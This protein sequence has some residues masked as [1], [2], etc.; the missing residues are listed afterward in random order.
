MLDKTWRETNFKKNTTSEEDI[1]HFLCTDIRTNT[2]LI[3]L[4][5]QEE[6]AEQENASAA[7][8]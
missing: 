5:L 4:T 6:K 3:K 2:D 7:I 1:S 8:A